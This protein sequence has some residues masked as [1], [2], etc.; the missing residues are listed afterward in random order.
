MKGKTATSKKKQKT[1]LKPFKLAVIVAILLLLSAGLTAIVLSSNPIPGPVGLTG[2][3]GPQGEV[4]PQGLMGPEGPQGEQGIQGVQGLQGE[5]GEPGVNS[6][7]QIVQTSSVEEISF[8]ELAK[9]SWWDLS[10]YDE[11]MKITIDTIGNSKIFVEF[12]A[13]HVLETPSA[14][15]VRLVVDDVIISTKYMISA[16]TPASPSIYSCGHLEFL[17]PKLSIGEHTI[18][19]QFYNEFG[20]SAIV[21]RVLTVTEFYSN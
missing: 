3:V 18:I 17:T 14:I 15:W 9:S 8:N 4:G 5:Q 21:D 13:T 1:F 16:A 20:N 12:S 10:V 19:V 2:S 7:I 11:N 6:V